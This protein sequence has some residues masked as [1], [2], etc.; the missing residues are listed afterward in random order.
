MG[1]YAP[2]SRRCRRGSSTSTT[3]SS[4]RGSASY[5]ARRL[6]VARGNCATLATEA[7]R[8]LAD[9]DVPCPTGA[10]VRPL[11]VRLTAPSP[12]NEEVREAPI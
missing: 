10:T 2:E 3:R 1:T 7:R 6:Q 11:Q 4:S 9:W 12:Q 5:V 8:R